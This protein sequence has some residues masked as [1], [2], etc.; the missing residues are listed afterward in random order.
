MT[1]TEWMQAFFIHFFEKSVE[2][3]YAIKSIRSSLKAVDMDEFHFSSTC[4]CSEESWKRK[5]ASEIESSD[6]VVFLYSATSNAKPKKF[7][8]VKYELN[9]AFRCKKVVFMVLLNPEEQEYKQYVGSNAKN[10][11]NAGVFEGTEGKVV[12]T[13]IDGL[14]RYLS[15]AKTN[16]TSI[17]PPSCKDI[18]CCV[19]EIESDYGIIPKTDSSVFYNSM[20]VHLAVKQKIL[21]SMINSSNINPDSLTIQYE[22]M[23]NSIEN[24]D[25]RRQTNNTVYTTINTAL[26]ALVAAS[27]SIIMS[28]IDSLAGVT[29]AVAMFIMIPLIGRQICNSWANSLNR[30]KNL[31][32]GK[33]KTLEMIESRLPLNLNKAEWE[34]LKSKNY[35]T[36]SEDAKLPYQMKRVYEGLVVVGIVL[37]ALSI[38]SITGLISY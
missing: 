2:S 32:S 34:V 10:I 36:A 29:L 15:S 3:E 21:E 37:V 30:Y 4:N 1:D 5:S 7:T 38:L 31:R 24:L 8:N 16:Q 25:E 23:F 9:E 6:F 14:V 11:P 26:I 17:I 19:K 28:S 20:Q 33:F 12:V 27:L 13:D 22:V 18:D 35:V